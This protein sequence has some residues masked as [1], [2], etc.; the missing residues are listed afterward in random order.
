MSTV[1]CAKLNKE[2]PALDKAPFPGPAGQE[3]LEKVSA[4]AWNDWM[5]FQTILINE[6]RLNLMDQK[7]REF[8]ADARTKYFFEPG[9]LD[10]PEQFVDPGIP[11][12]G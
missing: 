10:L 3:I 9:E 8:L 7:A 5:N 12:L 6:N 11:K 4:Q 1:L 2:L